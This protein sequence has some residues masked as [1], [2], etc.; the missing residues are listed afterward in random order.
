M[1]PLI[2]LLPIGIKRAALSAA[3][4][5]KT[6]SQT[7]EIG[8]INRFQSALTGSS[9]SVVPPSSAIQSGEKSQTI[10][11]NACA[12][13][14]FIPSMTIDTKSIIPQGNTPRA[15][16]LDVPQDGKTGDAPV[17]F[18]GSIPL[19]AQDLP[20]GCLPE[21]VMLHTAVE[22][23][24]ASSPPTSPLTEAADRV[25]MEV[26]HVLNRKDHAQEVRLFLKPEVL[27]GAEVHIR[28]THHRLEVRF[29]PPDVGAET[30]LLQGRQQLENRLKARTPFA[31]VHISVQLR[32]RRSGK[33]SFTEAA[34]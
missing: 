14:A 10:P 8:V 34:G 9:L 28:V 17:M 4:S 20:T 12:E 7:V 1:Q 6:T 23:T 22:K 27:S 19:K 3:R 30:L 5:E 31:D 13:K 26:F 21:T 15:T 2:E 11:C 24:N 32:L 18:D 16:D 25:A 33:Q 29:M